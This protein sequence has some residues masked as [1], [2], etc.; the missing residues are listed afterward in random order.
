MRKLFPVL[1]A[2]AQ[3]ALG[4]LAHGQAANYPNR[5]I[6]YVVPYPP[7]GVTDTTP[8]LNA[9]KLSEALKQ[10]LE[11]DHEKAARKFRRMPLSPARSSGVWPNC[12]ANSASVM[13]S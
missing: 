7:G 3:A 12:W 13:S 9:T 4:T 5:P 2:A 8:R 6:T 1:L 10:P 11:I